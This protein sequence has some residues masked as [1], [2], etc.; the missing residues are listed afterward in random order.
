MHTPSPIKSR[1]ELSIESEEN[2][3]P[4]TE[5]LKEF[6]FVNNAKKVTFLYKEDDDDCENELMKFEEDERRTAQLFEELN[7]WL[8][9]KDFREGGELSNK[10]TE[11]LNINYYD[12]EMNKHFR[13]LVALL[14]NLFMEIKQPS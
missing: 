8:G 1:K 11:L 3:K 10:L 2:N 14:Q 13:G 5:F 7:N 4:D 6:D 12:L 9:P